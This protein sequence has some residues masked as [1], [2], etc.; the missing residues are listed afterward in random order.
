[1][2]SHIL[3]SAFLNL[4]RALGSVA[5]ATLFLYYSN[6]S[7]IPGQDR[8]DSASDGD[9][10]AFQ[11]IGIGL[12]IFAMVRGWLGIYT[13][14]KVWSAKHSQNGIKSTLSLKISRKLGFGLSILDL[15][16]LVIYPISSTCGIYGLL[17]YRHPDT[18]DF[19][20]GKFSLT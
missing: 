17:V 5:L 13:L 10:M 8:Q 7:A 12:L 2:I 6:R 19:Y 4:V 3:T 11:I 16:N 15:L 9:L 18:V 1:M 20:E 14:F